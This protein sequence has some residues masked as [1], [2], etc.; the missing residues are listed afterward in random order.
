MIRP[1]PFQTKLGCV[2]GVARQVWG[3]A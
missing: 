1:P 3:S 2:V